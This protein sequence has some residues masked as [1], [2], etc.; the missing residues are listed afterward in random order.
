MH[1]LWP[2]V[3][4]LYQLGRWEEVADLAQ[5]DEAAF[6]LEPAIEC[7]FVRDGPVI[8][9]AALAM[10]GRTVEGHRLAALAGDPLADRLSASA[11]QAR[12][13]TLTGRPEI[14]RA[15]SADKALEH[16]AYGP[17]HAYALV[18]ALEALEDWLALT[19]FLPHARTSIA[20]NA[21]LSPLLDRALGR[22]RVAAGDLPAARRLLRR[23]AAAFG[24][25]GMLFE[26]VRAAA[27]LDATAPQDRPPARP[28]DS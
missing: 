11:W 6:R 13:A 23:S 10:L 21:A 28:H 4:G 19:A 5:Q 22:A 12:F 1:T 7:Q 20:G 17:Q 27:A 26:A 18:E 14:A 24:R 16:R 9:G 8:V 3:A 25:L 2:I 15:I